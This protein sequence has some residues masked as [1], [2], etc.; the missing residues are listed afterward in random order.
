MKPLGRPVADSVKAWQDWPGRRS[1]RPLPVPVASR[2]NVPISSGS[3]PGSV[4]FSAPASSAVRP[5]WAR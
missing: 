3:G 5:W 4:R 2:K 1:S